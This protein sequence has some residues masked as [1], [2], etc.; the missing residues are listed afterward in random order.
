[1]SGSI[2]AGNLN[3][4]NLV[5]LSP[6]GTF[7]L[8]PSQTSLSIYESIFTPGIVCDVNVVDFEDNLGQLVMTGDEF[9]LVSLETP[10]SGTSIDYLSLIHI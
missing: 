1:M 6:R 5:V 2:S 4:K 8:P 9:L 3:I 10:I 7:I